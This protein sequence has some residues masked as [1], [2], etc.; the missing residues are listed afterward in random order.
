LD[1]KIKPLK[2]RLFGRF[3]ASVAAVVC[4]VAWLPGDG[5]ALPG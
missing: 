4:W 2:K 1:A 5:P 3:G